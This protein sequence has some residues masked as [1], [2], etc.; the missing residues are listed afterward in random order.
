M[1]KTLFLLAV[2]ASLFWGAM[3][4]Q[5]EE[6]DSDRGRQRQG[7]RPQAGE[8]ERPAQTRRSPVFI[9]GQV[10]ME[11]GTPPEQPVQVE[12]VCYGA[13][14]RQVSAF[15]GQ[16]QLEFGNKRPMAVMDASVG[17]GGATSD[18]EFHRGGGGGFGGGT[19]LGVMRSDASTVDLS[20]CQLRAV[21]GGFQSDTLQLGR[22]RSL[23]RPDVGNIVLHRQAGVQGTSV[24]ATTLGAPKK[25]KKSYQN[26]QKELRK[27]KPKY[28]KA[29]K[30]LEKA[31]RE[32]PQFA[33]AW[34]MLAET[35]LAMKD[36][37]G[38]QQALKQAIATD[39]N[40]LSPVLT[41]ARIELEQR[42]WEEVARLSDGVVE[43]NPYHTYAYY[44][45]AAANYSLG[46]YGRA[47]KSARTVVESRDG[48]RFPQSYF[49][50]GGIMAQQG[51]IPSA[52]AEFNRFLQVE[53]QG[54][55]AEQARQILAE[56][57]Q[58]G[59]IGSSGPA[60]ASPPR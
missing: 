60:A 54:A 44:L 57:Q 52:S 59:L 3:W 30:E 55:L 31:V 18:D 58:Q 47:E 29:V 12:M 24:S 43:L 49:I 1:G 35:R 17:A 2:V 21:L 9:T 28:S 7:T 4:G 14:R 38:A 53:P 25:A 39:P 8:R 26:A 32:Y 22:R 13:V 41:L 5:R 46:Q 33:V 37:S 40:Y 27:K 15:R 11:D 20:G 19:G 48:G 23:D 34:Q 50:L 6:S 45:N 10:L 16:F 42:R 51:N 56:W 36:S